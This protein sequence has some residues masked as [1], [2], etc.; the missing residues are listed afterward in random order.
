MEV[1]SGRLPRAPH[2]TDG[3]ASFYSLSIFDMKGGEMAEM[4]LNAEA[5]VEYDRNTKATSHAGVNNFPIR[6]CDDRHPCVTSKVEAFMHG[7][8]A[9]DR[10]A[11]WSEATCY[12]G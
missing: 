5:V 10:V 3:A 12:P 9:C 2:F 1:R 11:S 8:L 6:W 7:R 4:G